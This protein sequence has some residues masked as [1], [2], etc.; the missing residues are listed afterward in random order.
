MWCV[1]KNIKSK[2]R[3]VN[4]L[5][6]L[7]SS[8]ITHLFILM[9]IILLTTLSALLLLQVAEESCKAKTLQG[10]KTTELE[11]KIRT[12]AVENALRSR[13]K[14]DV[15]QGTGYSRKSN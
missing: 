4:H 10:F 15:M 3:S 11:Y 1:F 7:N 5:T 12:R 14:H 9:T 2:F 6:L 8:T 13:E